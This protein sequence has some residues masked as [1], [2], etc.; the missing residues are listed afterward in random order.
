VLV[1]KVIQEYLEKERYF[2]SME[3]L[4]YISSH[5][6]KAS[7]DI[8]L[9]GIKAAIRALIDKNLIVEK[10]KIVSKDVLSNKNR[11]RIY[12]YIEKNP[13]AN[14]TKIM[15]GVNLSIPVTAW[16]LNILE[17]FNFIKKEREG[18]ASIYFNLKYSPDD[19]KLLALLTKKISQ[20]V[21]KFLLENKEPLSANNI[22]TKLKLNRKTVANYIKKLTAFEI[23]NEQ[24][25]SYFNIYSLN[26]ENFR[27]IVKGFEELDDIKP[28]SASIKDN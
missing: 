5:M 3:I 23:V 18:G 28:W 24:K 4:P 25:D 22:S 6:S 14:F 7:I 21:I 12:S 11:S 8:N 13:G 16:H 9:N 2:N 10:S 27:K 15:N 20:Q 26:R 17:R 1:F 19:A